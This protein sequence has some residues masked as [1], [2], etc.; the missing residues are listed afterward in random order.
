MRISQKNTNFA[1]VI[2]IDRHIEILL[3]TNDCVIVP[4][5]GGFMAHHFCARYDEED[6]LFLPPLRTLGFNG[7]LRMNDSLLAQSYVEAYDISY[8]EAVRRIESEVSELKQY[9]DNEGRYELNGIGVLSRNTEGRIEF[10]PCEAGILTPELY[11]L[12]SFD[13][14]LLEGAVSHQSKKAA[15]KRMPILHRTKTAAVATDTQHEEPSTEDSATQERA[16][17]IKMSWVR[18]AVAVAAAVIAFFMITTPVANSNQTGVAISSVDIPLMK[19]EAR[20]PTTVKVDVP[21]ATTTAEKPEVKP[22]PKTTTVTEQTATTLTE[23]KSTAEPEPKVAA[24]PKPKPT[25]NRQT[26]YCIV[27]ASQVNQRNAEAFVAQLKKQGL[28]DVRIFT[29]NNIRRVV[30]GHYATEGQAYASL[31]K[32]HEQKDCSEAWVYKIKP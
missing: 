10:E 19:K 28:P 32:I 18:S 29:Q 16:I 5:L 3:L 26:G 17:V 27:L 8:P 9:I 12:S 31:Q 23:P 25:V 11:G 1:T 6:G 14:P 21:V 13:M 30:C 4:D 24:Q 7:Q 15:H 20:K 2:E 22:E